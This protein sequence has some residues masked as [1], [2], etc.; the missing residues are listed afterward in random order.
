MA[1]ICPISTSSRYQS[2]S[3]LYCYAVSFKP[4]G[5]FYW[6]TCTTRWVSKGQFYYLYLTILQYMYHVANIRRHNEWG[7]WDFK[8]TTHLIQCMIITI[9]LQD[10]SRLP[11]SYLQ[12]VITL[13]LLLTLRTVDTNQHSS[14]FKLNKVLV[15]HD[16]YPILPHLCRVMGTVSVMWREC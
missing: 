7:N 2:F 13:L 8:L 6:P 9:F 15:I 14:H 16:Y 12:E 5:H 10:L 11:V 1:N 4:T 3:L